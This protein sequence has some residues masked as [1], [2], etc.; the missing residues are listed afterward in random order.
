MA[1]GIIETA[2]SCRQV[3]RVNVDPRRSAIRFGNENDVQSVFCLSIIE[4]DV[5]QFL[6]LLDVL[7]AINLRVSRKGQWANGNLDRAIGSHMVDCFLTGW[8]P[9]VKNTRQIPDLPGLTALT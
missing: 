5:S 8:R 9:H 6:F 4:V 7:L 3:D 1:F 2:H